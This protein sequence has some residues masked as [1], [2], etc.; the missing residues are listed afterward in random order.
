MVVKSG[1]LLLSRLPFSG[2]GASGVYIAQGSSG[3]TL[4]YLTINQIL[5]NIFA[6]VC[7]FRNFSTVFQ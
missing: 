5:F 3:E 2:L 6:S 1:N 4:F 7:S